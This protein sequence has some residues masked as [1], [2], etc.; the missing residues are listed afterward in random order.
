MIPLVDLLAIHNA[1]EQV[2]VKTAAVHEA[3]LREPGEMRE[4]NFT[5]IAV[6]DLARMF[7]LYD[8][9][10]FDG[11]LG[12]T[13]VKKADGPV[14]FRLSST[15]TR[16]GGKTIK[17]QERTRD[18]RSRT[19]FQIAIAS[20]LLFTTFADIQRPVPVCGILCRDRLQALQRLMEHEI[21]HL[22][23]LLAW[24]NSSCKAS[25]FK[26]LAQGIFA[27]ADVTHELVTP[28]EIA[29][30]R[31][32]VRIGSMVEFQ[33]QGVRRFGQVNRIHRRATVLVESEDGVSYSD[34]KRYEK[35]YIPLEDLKAMV[36]AP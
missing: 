11:W 23:E 16:A 13:V 9:G 36:I 33:F 27:H 22:A 2:S 17:T 14:T 1:P 28:R 5:V 29:A 24:G 19:H 12:Q 35:F 18:G 26:S 25:R 7:S 3:I 6:D 20:E 15:M 21:I 4:A 32:D 30:V 8:H 31:H 34:G 10:F